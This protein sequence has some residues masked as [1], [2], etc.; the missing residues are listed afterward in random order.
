[1]IEYLSFLFHFSIF[2]NCHYFSS[3]PL[4]KQ[5]T[6]IN[7]TVSAAPMTSFLSLIA[8]GRAIAWIG[9]GAKN[10]FLQRAWST[11]FGTNKSF[12]AAIFSAIIKHSECSFKNKIHVQ[13]LYT[14][15]SAN[16]K[17]Q[18]YYHVVNP[19]KLP[20]ILPPSE[21]FVSSSDSSITFILFLSLE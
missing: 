16:W 7:N 18:E 10:L 13:T 21:D 14:N 15:E 1:M 17:S 2:K 6:W 8:L 3:Y 4:R 12:H 19:K 11:S 5:Y 9:V 20:L